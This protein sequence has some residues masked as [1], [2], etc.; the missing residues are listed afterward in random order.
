MLEKLFFN[1]FMGIDFYH[2]AYSFFIYGCGCW[3]MEC[4]FESIRQKKLVLD[5][6]FNYGPICTIYG[7]AFLFLYF[8]MKPL[9]GKWVW[10]YIAGTLFATVLEYVVAVI[11]ENVFHEKL[12][13]YS[14]F[15]FNFQGR[16]CLYIS[17]A[18]GGLVILLFALFQPNVMRLIDL[19]PRS[20]GLPIIIVL[21]VVYFTDLGLS[22][23]ASSRRRKQEAAETGTEEENRNELTEQKETIYEGN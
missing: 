14:D 6:G 15:P 13:D 1:E 4:I 8:S 23:A 17:L 16:I 9:D 12:W 21:I 3:L 2:T 19:I 22:F 7:V 20:W 10:L 18:W 11:M 5:R